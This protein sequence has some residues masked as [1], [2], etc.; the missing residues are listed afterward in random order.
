MMNGFEIDYYLLCLISV[1]LGE[2]F[3][4]MGPQINLEELQALLSP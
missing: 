1:Q 4:V 2:E 3:F